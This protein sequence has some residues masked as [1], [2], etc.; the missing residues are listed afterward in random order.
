MD[1]KDMTYK[2]VCSTN[3]MEYYSAMKK[4]ENLHLKHMYG[5]LFKSYKDK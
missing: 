2:C 1:K 4:N 3:T 5:I